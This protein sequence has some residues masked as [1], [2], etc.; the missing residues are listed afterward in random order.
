MNI[1]IAGAGKTGY[2]LAKALEKEN[3]LIIVERDKEVCARVSSEIKATVINRSCVD[4]E[5]I[6]EIKI[7]E[8]DIYVAVTGDD[9]ANFLTSVYAKQRGA[10]RVVARVS[11]P[12]YAKLLNKLGVETIVPDIAIAEKMAIEITRPAV[13]ELVTLGKSNFDILEMSVPEKYLGKRLV[14][15]P[16]CGGCVL[17]ALYRKGK[18]VIPNEETL[19][20]GDKIILVCE[21]SSVK[22]MKKTLG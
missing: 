11:E 14:D 12:A 8:S 4:P 2:A 10:P 13:Y 17:I 3:K 21:T 5:L 1:I 16:R 9:R 6:E 22:E 7:E 19:E 15:I 20:E 18:F